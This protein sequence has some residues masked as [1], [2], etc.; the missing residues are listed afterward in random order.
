MFKTF[1]YT[2]ILVTIMQIFSAWWTL[3]PA[4]LLISFLF[5]KTSKE[6]ILS[7][8]LTV[9]ILWA[10]LAL[11]RDVSNAGILTERIAAVLGA[12]GLAPF[13]FLISGLLGGIVGGLS[14]YTGYLL[15]QVREVKSP[16]SSLYQH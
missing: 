5:A 10:G 7:G 1:I 14:S 13:L 2:F 12:K 4:A 6:A 15:K 9:F 11:F 16:P 3:A 8:F